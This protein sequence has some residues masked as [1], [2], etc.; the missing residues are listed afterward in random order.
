MEGSVTGNRIDK[1]ADLADPGRVDRVIDELAFTLG[2]YKACFS[3]NGQMLGGNRLFQP[4]LDIDFGDGDGSVIADQ[5]QDLLTQ[6][7][8]QGTLNKH[9]FFQGKQVY[10]NGVAGFLAV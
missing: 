10:L 5:P 4:Q 8:I 7:V 2:L 3:E 9:R 1:L 6:F